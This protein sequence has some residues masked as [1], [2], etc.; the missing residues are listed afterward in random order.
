MLYACVNVGKVGEFVSV[1]LLEGRRVMH[2]KRR[3]A[4]LEW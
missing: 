3:A 4:N 1:T 2:I